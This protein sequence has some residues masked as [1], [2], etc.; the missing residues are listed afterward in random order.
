MYSWE[1]GPHTEDNKE[2]EQY[3][4]WLSNNCKCE[5][6]CDCSDFYKWQ[7]ERLSEYWECI[8]EDEG[9]PA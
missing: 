9:E 8:L 1:E 7:E 6:Y 2:E 3:L 5:E 4:Q